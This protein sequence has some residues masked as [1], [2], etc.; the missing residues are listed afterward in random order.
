VA[1]GGFEVGVEALAVGWTSVELPVRF[2]VSLGFAAEGVLG[3]AD[4]PPQP[5]SKKAAKAKEIHF[6]MNRV[7]PARIEL[8][9]LEPPESISFSS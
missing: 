5:D 8:N 6:F 9:I 3:D 7:C 4:S 2:S 1:D